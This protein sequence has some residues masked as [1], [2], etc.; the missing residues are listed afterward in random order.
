MKKRLFLTFIIFNL[1][2]FISCSNNP[3]SIKTKIKDVLSSPAEYS[4]SVVCVKGKVT[5]SLV[6]LGM[7][8]FIISDGTGAIAIIPSKTFP[9]T[10]ENVTIKGYVQNAFVIGN[11]SLTVII[12][13]QNN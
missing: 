4:D 12:E 8:Y 2:F 5:E 13:S 7:G 9:K 1:L 10:G 11:E 3:L 6:L